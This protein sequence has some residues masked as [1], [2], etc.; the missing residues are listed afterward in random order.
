MVEQGHARLWGGLVGRPPREST[1]SLRHEVYS[2]L[3][4]SCLPS[5]L[6][7]RQGATAGAFRLP[8]EA[9]WP[10]GGARGNAP[11]QPFQALQTLQGDLPNFTLAFVVARRER[12]VDLTR[13]QHLVGV[14]IG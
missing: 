9:Q 4:L 5:T 1:A 2:P 12:P 14:K 13:S 11:Y 7:G 10:P 8:W 6:G 3:R